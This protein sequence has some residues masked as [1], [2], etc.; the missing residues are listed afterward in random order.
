MSKVYNSSLYKIGKNVAKEAPEAIK[1]LTEFNNRLSKY[2]FL[3]AIR[4][5]MKQ[6]HSSREDLKLTLDSAKKVIENKGRIK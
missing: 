2:A 5:L 6:V 4:H 3:S 1:L